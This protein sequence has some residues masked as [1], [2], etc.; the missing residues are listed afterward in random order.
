MCTHSTGLC[1]I[2]FCFVYQYYS[3]RCWGT[4][5]HHTQLNGRNTFVMVSGTRCYQLVVHYS[6]DKGKKREGKG[7]AVFLLCAVL[8]LYASCD[9]NMYCILQK[10]QNKKIR[11][12]CQSKAEREMHLPWHAHTEERVSRLCTDSTWKKKKC[13]T[14]TGSVYFFPTKRTVRN[15]FGPCLLLLL[16][17]FIFGAS[18]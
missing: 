16:T 10:K 14:V 6:A 13:C 15:A 11:S 1:S 9:P 8:L 3:F 18:I 5:V 7:C 17:R 2:C 4:N 12:W